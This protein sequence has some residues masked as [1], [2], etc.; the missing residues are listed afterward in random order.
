M[1]AL[2]PELF[3]ILHRYGNDSCYE[4]IL[5]AS[6]VE[7]ITPHRNDSHVSFVDVTSSY[8]VKATATPRL[9]INNC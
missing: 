5:I 7:W 8:M 4:C 6:I 1:L 2:S 9:Y 3:G